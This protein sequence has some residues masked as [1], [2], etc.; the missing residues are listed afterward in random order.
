M[1]LE[2]LNKNNIENNERQGVFS[3]RGRAKRN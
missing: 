1:E 2:N 3:R